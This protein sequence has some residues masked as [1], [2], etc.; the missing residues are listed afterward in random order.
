VVLWGGHMAMTQGL[1][2]AMIADTAPAE[3]Y[4]TAYG[5]FNLA[6]GLA[7]LIASVLAGFLWDRLGAPYTFLAGALFAVLSLAVLGLHRLKVG[8]GRTAL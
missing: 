5:L 3:L 6:S 4:G 1:L 7:M 8:A 2:A